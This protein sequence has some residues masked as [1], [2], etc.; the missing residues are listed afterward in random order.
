[1]GNRYIIKPCGDVKLAT[2]SLQRNRI[3]T[4]SNDSVLQGADITHCL[5]PQP[6]L[7][8]VKH[9]GIKASVAGLKNLR[10]LVFKEVLRI[11]PGMAEE[12][13]LK[14]KILQ[15]GGTGERTYLRGMIIP[16][17]SAI[18][19][20]GYCIQTTL[21][22]LHITQSW[23]LRLV[24]EEL[25]VEIVTKLHRHMATTKKRYA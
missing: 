2:K 9:P 11:Q 24:T 19:G 7:E 16:A 1:M 20:V 22:V 14:T 10:M 17:N 12:P 21:N 4:G 25:C 3:T 18:R 5:C 15:S 23:L 6:P 13:I 8:K